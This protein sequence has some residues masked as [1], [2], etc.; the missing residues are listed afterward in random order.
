MSK[1]ITVNQKLAVISTNCTEKK[2]M[3]DFIEIYQSSTK[4]AVENILNMC[5][6]VK[7]VD[8]KYKAK[9]INYFD[10]TYF[11]ATV[12]LDQKS[13]TY[14]KYRKIGEHATRFK[15]YMELL[16]S[17]YTV[18]FEIATLDSEKFEELIES[19]KITPSLSLEKL[20]QLTNSS[21]KT[22]NPDDVYFKVS[23][24]LKNLCED[25]RKYLQDTLIKFMSFNDIEIIVPDKHKDNLSYYT[26]LISVPK[27]VQSVNKK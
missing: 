17:A 16:P 8:E 6:A 14:R 15:K 7:E 27:V 12:Q 25:S 2:L 11:C 4:S 23:F 18:L 19:N 5:I 9:L 22:Q 13:P 26:K 21:T 10:V 24:N 1:N 3:D 20:K